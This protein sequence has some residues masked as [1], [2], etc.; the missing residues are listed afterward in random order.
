MKLDVM[1]L[2]MGCCCVPVKMEHE[3]TLWAVVASIFGAF[4]AAKVVV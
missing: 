2:L 3:W 1:L 4:L